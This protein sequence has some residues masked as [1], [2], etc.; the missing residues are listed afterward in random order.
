[1]RRLGE[2]LGM[3]AFL[4]ATLCSVAG[5]GCANEGGDGP[6]AP[7]VSATN[8]VDGAVAP[9]L[10]DG[11]VSPPGTPADGGGGQGGRDAR[12]PVAN[13]DAAGDAGPAAGPGGHAWCRRL[14]VKDNVLPAGAAFT[15]GFPSAPNDAWVAMTRARSL[16]VPGDIGYIAH[17]PHLYHWDG[18]T[19][20]GSGL[21]PIFPKDDLRTVYAIYT[22]WGA[23][24]TDVWA[25]GENGL[26]MHW[27]GTTWEPAVIGT[28]LKNK[29]NI[30]QIIGTAA[31]NVFALTTEG[32]YRWDG[33]AW[34]VHRFVGVTDFVHAVTVNQA[35]RMFVGV[36]PSK[37]GPEQCDL[38]QVGGEAATCQLRLDK[39]GSYKVLGMDGSTG[40]PWLTLRHEKTFLEYDGYLLAPGTPTWVNH[41]FKDRSV[42]DLR[43]FST[44]DVWAAGVGVESRFDGSKWTP[45][46]HPKPY[47]DKES[48]LIAFFGASSNDLYAIAGDE[49]DFFGAF[50]GEALLHWNGQAW[51]IIAR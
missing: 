4:A 9:T 33:S 45:L 13:A 39:W 42:S 19:L 36:R 8:E 43:V 20:C 38:Y 30:F 18:N 24:P 49:T 2:P 25:A 5:A 27:D 23:S 50:G 29:K 40:T 15:R 47:P 26:A 37:P 17:Y 46:T 51:R 22:I 10:P 34:A 14:G 41:R 35:G 28:T 32:V 1:M 44:T 21:D 31:N 12:P 6:A 3:V 7:T 11:A 16:P 48:H